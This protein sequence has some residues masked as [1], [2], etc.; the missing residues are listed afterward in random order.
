M[1]SLKLVFVC[2]SVFS[3]SVDILVESKTPYLQGVAV[4][5]PSTERDTAA[6]S[7][8]VLEGNGPERTSSLLCQGLKP[9][10]FHQRP[11]AE[12]NRAACCTKATPTTL[13]QL[14][15]GLTQRVA[16][17]TQEPSSLTGGR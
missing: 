8:R 17:R 16:F 3:Q 4:S 5:G 2:L 12:T 14:S 13:T 15:H 11:E 6:I 9:A 10:C 7:S 1:I